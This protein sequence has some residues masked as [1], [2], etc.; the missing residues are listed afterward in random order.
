MRRWLVLSLCFSLA[1]GC[2]TAGTSRVE[3]ATSP[4]DPVLLASYVRQ[5]PVGSRV[6]VNLVG[7]QTLSGTLMQATASAIVVQRATRIP[8]PPETLPLARVA[9][10][11]PDTNAG[12]PARAIMIGAIAGAG[13]ALAVFLVLAA[14]LAGD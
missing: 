6:R 14:L 1:S 2:A 7:G 11:R 8:E 5:L 13:G 12:N 9:A 3:P 10:V 4:V